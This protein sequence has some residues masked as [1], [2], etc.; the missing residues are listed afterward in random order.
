MNR[1]FFLLILCFIC[2]GVL[3]AKEEKVKEEK[4]KEEK[5]AKA[6]A[7]V[8]AGPKAAAAAPPISAPT[9]AST[10]IPAVVNSA[11]PVAPPVAGA[12]GYPPPDKVPP[13]DSPEVQEWLKLVDMT[14]V[15]QL[16]L[17]KA[18]E[19]AASVVDPNACWWTCQKCTR[20]DD[21][22]VCPN[23]KDWGLTYD[24][25]PTINTP[26]LLDYLKAHQIKATMF[27]VG[28]R[29][30]QNGDIL[31]REF[32]EGHHIAVHTWSHTALTSLTNEQIVAEIKWTEKAIKDTIGVTPLYFRP[33]YGD[34]DDRVRAIVRQL[35]YKT[36]I[37]TDGFDTQDWQIPAKQATQ[38]QVLNNFK[39]YLT[40]VQQMNSGFIVL[41]H[42]LYKESVDVA[43]VDILPLALQS[44]LRMMPVPDCLGDK[45]PYLETRGNVTLSAL[46]SAMPN[47]TSSTSL[48]SVASA[49]L[50]SATLK[51]STSSGATVVAAV[52]SAAMAVFCSLILHF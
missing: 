17:S 38:A 16:P 37:W 1:L 6:Q 8:P 35:G 14:K 22:V 49:P 50:A 28:S 34:Y 7:G 12:A 31:R 27:V 13:V 5:A 48:P 11:P 46:P 25:G 51:G 43:I 23:R 33:P 47:M 41:E 2:A 19:C 30:V 45:S 32:Q 15:P 39:Q 9:V 21:V 40:K 36:V 26:P 18:G 29:V 44:Q 42:D 10:P 3:A 52:L 20:P 4:V 24:D